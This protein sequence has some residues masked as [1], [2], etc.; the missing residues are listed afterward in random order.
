M[1]LGAIFLDCVA[2]VE[3]G[4]DREEGKK[5]GDWGERVRVRLPSLFPSCALFS[6]PRPPPLFAPAKPAAIFHLIN[7]HQ[8]SFSNWCPPMVSLRGP[9]RVA[10][11]IT[12]RRSLFLVCKKSWINCW[13]QCGAALKE[14]KMQ[15]RCIKANLVGETEGIYAC[16]TLKAVHRRQ[17]SLL[18]DQESLF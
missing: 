5:E 1:K 13:L 2:G 7:R 8:C 9:R 14:S 18:I 12:T 16:F 11:T 4:G 15:K 17:T 3:R 6:L 10:H